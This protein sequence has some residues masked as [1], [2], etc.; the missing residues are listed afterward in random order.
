MT[1]LADDLVGVAVAGCLDDL[2][3]GI[4][5]GENADIVP[6]CFNRILTVM[7]GKSLGLVAV[8]QAVVVDITLNTAGLDLRPVFTLPE[9]IHSA[10]SVQITDDLAVL[11]RFT[12]DQSTGADRVV[13]R[14]GHIL[15]C[16]LIG[17]VHINTECRFRSRGGKRHTGCKN[18]SDDR[19]RLF[20]FSHFTRLR[21]CK[22]ISFV[23]FITKLLNNR[24]M[25]IVIYYIFVVKSFLLLNICAG[26]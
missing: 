24:Y 9:D 26:D 19:S 11:I 20:L 8:D 2:R 23:T 4:A 17:S 3:I 13:V 12:S 21:K 18:S 10:A 5:L 7:L 1:V 16:V 6:G 15:P 14:H 25:C 22:Y